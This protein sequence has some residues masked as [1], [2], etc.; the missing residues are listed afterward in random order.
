MVS[1]TA[2]VPGRPM[3][4][5]RPGGGQRAVAVE[6]GGGDGRGPVTGDGAGLDG[7]RDPDSAA[8]GEHVPRQDE[9]VL[10]V[11]VGNHLEPYVPVDAG[12]LQEVHGR[13]PAGQGVRRD[14]EPAAV[15]DDGEHVAA[16]PEM[17]GELGRPGQVTAGVRGHDPAVEHDGGVRH[18]P[19][20]GHEHPAARHE[21]AV[22]MLAVDPGA[23]PGPVV[24]AGPGQVRDGVRQRDAR[25]AAVVMPGRFRALDV[26]AAEQPALVE[27]VASH[28]VIQHRGD[29]AWAGAAEQVFG[30]DAARH[31]SRPRGKA[32][33][34][35]S[36]GQHA[37]GHVPTMSDLR[38][39]RDWTGRNV[40]PPHYLRTCQQMD[41]TSPRICVRIRTWRTP[42]AATPGGR[43]LAGRGVGKRFARP[44]A[45]Q[46]RGEAARGGRLK[47]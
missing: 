40:R 3:A 28:Q 25:I 10:Q 1:A 4:Q 34:R 12:R 32:G 6:Q 44:G 29:R 24:P 26:R 15:H 8:G 30:A 19:V 5:R 35:G 7:R 43:Q 23:L 13:R 16:G 22:E 18:D 2:C 46:R 9:D 21:R 41:W 39:R 11:D 27:I 47:E 31:G 20:E 33:Q 14:V 45:P 42:A 38:C 37:A 17:A 36:P